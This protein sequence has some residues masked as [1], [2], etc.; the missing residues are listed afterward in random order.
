MP[1]SVKESKFATLPKM[2]FGFELVFHSAPNKPF[3]ISAPPACALL[4]K[5]QRCL[6]SG[7][8]A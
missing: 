2:R 5:Y 1:F 3:T 6:N 7:E 8:M 4:G